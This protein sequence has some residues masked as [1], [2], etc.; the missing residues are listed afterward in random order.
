MAA[1]YYKVDVVLNSQA[2]S[3]GLPSPQSV[4]VTIPLIGPQGPVGATGS[5]GATGPAN[6]LAIGTVSTGAA[7]SN[8]S[9]TITGTAP[10]QTLDLTIPRGD[11]GDTGDTGA[12]GPANSLAI[13]TVSTGA[14][15][16]NADATIT[17]TAPNQTLNL[18]IPVGATGATGPTGPQGPAGTQTTSASD[19]TSGTLADAR[20]SS[21]VPLKDAANTFTANQTLNG[22]NNVAPN[23]TAASGSSVITRQ[24]LDDSNLDTRIIR[25]RDDFTNGGRTGG[26]IGETGWGTSN[27]GG[28]T[29]VERSSAG[30]MPN[31]SAFRLS[32]GATASNY[33]RIFTCNGI[34]GTSNPATVAGWHALAIM[35]LPTVTDVTVSAGFS[36][37]PTDIDFNS[38]LIGWRF[39]AGVDTNW[40]FVTKNDATAYASSTLTTLVD[41][42]TAPVADTFYKFEM[43]CVTAGTIEFRLNGGTWLTSS[44]NVPSS[45]TAGL[46]YIIVGTQTNAARTCD[47]DLVAWNQTVSR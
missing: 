17:G 3:V 9:A 6:S 37:N 10:S 4:S 1:A 40:Q 29:I 36:A 24:L 12:T 31:H 39:K 47:V 14:A 30:V 2:V 11:K 38:R 27:A 21:N 35:A 20:L 26:T 13:G 46:F 18:T 42:G 7:G 45:S 16:S 41:S 43:R 22:T 34:F 8:A 32:T 5:T 25:F 19:L 33:L 15:G 23:Q 44:T 28:G